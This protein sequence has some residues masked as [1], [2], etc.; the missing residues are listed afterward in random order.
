MHVVLLL[1]CFVLFSL[2]MHFVIRRSSTRKELALIFLIGVFLAY[3]VKAFLLDMDPSIFATYSGYNIYTSRLEIYFCFVVFV[4]FFLAG[5]HIPLKS[6][7]FNERKLPPSSDLWSWVNLINSFLLISF[8]IFNT[9]IAS[10]SDLLSSNVRKQFLSAQI[11]TG[12]SSLL[13]VFTMP[14]L[15]LSY[16]NK[17]WVIFYLSF[18]ISLFS[19]LAVGS[20]MYLFGYCIAYIL[21]RFRPSVFGCLIALFAM[22]IIG[23]IIY[24]GF[25]GDALSEIN[26]SLALSYL[27][28]TFD[29]AD[30][31]NTYINKGDYKLYYGETVT[32]DLLIT[33]FPR[34]IWSSKPFLFGGIRITTDM[35]S[36]LADVREVMSTFPPGLFLETYANFYILTPIFVILLGFFFNWVSNIKKTQSP[37]RY[38]FYISLCANAPGFFRGIGSIVSFVVPV[39]LL[40]IVLWLISRIKFRLS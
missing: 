13:V 17:K 34:A 40:L 4:F 26:G 21:C 8:V 24:M 27:M 23:S 30:L 10:F 12:W 9:H 25:L 11:G 3:P 38:A 37:F 7:V 39:S 20:R 35:F 5:Y 1:L 15:V 31:L 22:G 29:G 16:Q 19:L 28:H 33:Y 32:E 18:F 2:A 36:D 14:L 6:A